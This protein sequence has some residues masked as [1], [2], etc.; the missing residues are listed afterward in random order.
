MTGA[1]YHN[2]EGERFRLRVSHLGG[3]SK[4]REKKAKRKKWKVKSGKWKLCQ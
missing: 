4:Q 2:S 3:I 1:R